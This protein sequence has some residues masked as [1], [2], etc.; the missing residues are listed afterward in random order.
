METRQVLQGFDWRVLFLA[1][2]AFGCFSCS[3]PPVPEK[4]SESYS[5]TSTGWDA[6]LSCVQTLVE[7]NRERECDRIRTADGRGYSYDQYYGSNYQY[8][9]GKAQTASAQLSSTQKAAGYSAYL[10]QL[11]SATI[12][13][14]EQ[15][16]QALA[17]S[18]Q[19]SAK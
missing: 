18:A 12:A 7:Y 19:L 1:V 6:Y 17:Q 5:S 13:E 9:Q 4:D 15:Q 10:S 2:V 16:W 11:D 3:T 8:Y 14:L